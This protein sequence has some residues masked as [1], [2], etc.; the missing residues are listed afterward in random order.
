MEHYNA[1]MV[2]SPAPTG[3]I[4]PE[5]SITDLQQASSALHWRITYEKALLNECGQMLSSDMQMRMA[6]SIA[7]MAIA[8][9]RIEKMTEY[10]LSCG[11]ST[12]IPFTVGSFKKLPA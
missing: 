10:L 4:S 8:S 9:S 11:A 2:T 1:Y 5:M 7:D 12:A 3:G 6:R